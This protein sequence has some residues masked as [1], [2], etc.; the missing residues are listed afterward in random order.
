MNVCLPD[1]FLALLAVGA[2][3]TGVVRQMAQ[4]RREA[5]SDEDE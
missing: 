5:I 1:W 4:I 2:V 3:G